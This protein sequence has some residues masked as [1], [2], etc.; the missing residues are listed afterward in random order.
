MHIYLIPRRQ[1]CRRKK[2]ACITWLAV[3]WCRC[4][5]SREL[6]ISLQHNTTPGSA[7]RAPAA[8]WRHSRCQNHLPNR[9][10]RHERRRAARHHER[11]VILGQRRKLVQWARKH[12]LLLVRRW[13]HDRVR[14]LRALDLDCRTNW[15]ARAARVRGPSN[16]DCGRT[17]RARRKKAPGR[18]HPQ[19]Y[20]RA[21]HFGHVL[22]MPKSTRLATTRHRDS[23]LRTPLSWTGI[24]AVL[25]ERTYTR[26]YGVTR[27]PGVVTCAMSSHRMTSPLWKWTGIPGS[28]SRMKGRRFIGS[29]W[30]PWDRSLRLPRGSVENPHFLLFTIEHERERLGGVGLYKS[31][32]DIGSCLFWYTHCW[33]ASLG[34]NRISDVDVHDRLYWWFL[35]WSFWCPFSIVLRAW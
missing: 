4:Y 24:G 16:C 1:F 34:L 11:H 15:C 17:V 32:V 9:R 14:G 35:Q 8:P 6:N 10:N 3:R 33:R 29:M 28:G 20:A 12:R 5:R 13:R 25:T 19:D 27:R 30:M 26:S 7:A 2:D 18:A 22:S 31:L 21:T 23:L